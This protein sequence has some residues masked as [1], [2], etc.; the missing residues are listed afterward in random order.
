MNWLDTYATPGAATRLY[1]AQAWRAMTEEQRH[2][3]ANAGGRVRGIRYHLNTHPWLYLGAMDLAADDDRWAL[4]DAR[5]NPPSPLAVGVPTLD[6]AQKLGKV[7]AHSRVF[8]LALGASMVGAAT[9][10][11]LAQVWRRERT[12]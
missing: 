8:R 4:W 7:A 1:T 10:A 12:T 6:L 11:A 2:A 3:A 5:T 9:V